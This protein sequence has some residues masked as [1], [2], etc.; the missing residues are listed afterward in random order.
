VHKH[1][2]ER[3]IFACK[4][5]IC[6]FNGHDIYVSDLERIKQIGDSTHAICAFCHDLFKVT[7]TSK[8][9]I[10]PDYKFRR[11]RG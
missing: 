10:T 4:H 6:R 11:I 2:V 3:I 5:L 8:D 7:A 1:R 9:G